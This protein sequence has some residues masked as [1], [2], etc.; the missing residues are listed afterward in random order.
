MKNLTNIDIALMPVDGVYTMSATE[1]AN[2]V[3]EFKPKVA[4]PMHY[5]TISGV[6]QKSDAE[7]FKSL[8]KVRVE[9]LG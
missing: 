7:K 8:A 2:A 4:I 3:N 6:G 5:G 9:I 1:A